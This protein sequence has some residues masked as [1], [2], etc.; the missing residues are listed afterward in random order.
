MIFLRLKFGNLLVTPV[1]MD[2]SPVSA[3]AEIAQNGL[4]SVDA[5]VS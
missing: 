5:N 2:C 1:D 4:P 3:Y